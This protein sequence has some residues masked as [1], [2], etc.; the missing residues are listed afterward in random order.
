MGYIV[1]I[2]RY[3]IRNGFTIYLTLVAVLLLLHII[4]SILVDT[5]LGPARDAGI[6]T[7]LV[8][9]SSLGL[10]IVIFPASFY[11]LISRH[12]RVRAL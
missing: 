6:I 4:A 9:F 5:L 3:Y 1:S 11:P 8:L 12:L 7:P 2:S 10:G